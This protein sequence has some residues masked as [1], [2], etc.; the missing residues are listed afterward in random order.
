[1]VGFLGTYAPS[2][3]NGSPSPSTVMTAGQGNDTLIGGAGSTT[4]IGGPGHD[5]FDFFSDPNSQVAGGN[6]ATING[7]VSGQDKIDLANFS[8][9]TAQLFATQPRLTTAAPFG[10]SA[11]APP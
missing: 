7:F 8:E 5:I 10:T 3:D 11:T 1:M 2:P 4:M 9:T 6:H